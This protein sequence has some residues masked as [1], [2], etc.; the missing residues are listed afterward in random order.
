MITISV[1]FEYDRRVSELGID[2]D[3]LAQYFLENPERREER[4]YDLNRLRDEIGLSN[5]K[6]DY[7]EKLLAEIS[8]S[9]VRLN[10][11][12]EN[13]YNP[14]MLVGVG[15]L[16]GIVLKTGFDYAYK[17]FMEMKNTAYQNG[18]QIGLKEY[19]ENV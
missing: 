15:I 1:V 3:V 12:Q 4:T 8:K 18:Q 19:F 9:L 10:P 14:Y 6:G 17:K 2:S 13:Q 5:I 7:K 16:I 11:K